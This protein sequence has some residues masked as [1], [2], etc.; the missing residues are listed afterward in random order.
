[1]LKRVHEFRSALSTVHLRE[2]W[3]SV[4]DLRARVGAA[5]SKAV[6][7]DAAE[8]TSRPGWYRGPTPALTEFASLSAEVR[9]LRER[10]AVASANAKPL[11]LL[12]TL[13]AG[14]PMHVTKP[15]SSWGWG[16]RMQEDFR[17]HALDE[18]LNVVQ[19]LAGRFDQ[20]V[21]FPL[22]KVDTVYPIDELRFALV[23][24]PF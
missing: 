19:L 8:G 17:F 21:N 13:K 2:E 16:D 24:R 1:M 3:T 12:R 15:I 23:F 4:D 5:L 10:L 14:T 20:I 6:R 7:E 9:E 18:G 11:E 22:D